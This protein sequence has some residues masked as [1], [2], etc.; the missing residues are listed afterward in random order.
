M[1]VKA[2]ANYNTTTNFNPYTTAPLTSHIM[3]TRPVAFGGVIGG[4][5]GG[6]TTYGNYYS[7]S[8]YERKYDPIVINGYIYYT[9][10]PGSSSNPAAN[11]CINLY[12]GQTVWVDDSTNY[13][14]G[15]PAH[16]C[17]NSN[18]LNYTSAM[19]VKYSI[20]YHPT[21]T[22]ESHTYGPKEYFLDIHNIWNVT[23]RT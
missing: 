7:T 4:D 9:Q 6:T 11:I 2:A 5:A 1:Q 14:G 8:Q 3:W 23:G 12:T 22:V 15:S 13:G 20:T 16:N 18:W 21:N 10:F 17:P 19:L